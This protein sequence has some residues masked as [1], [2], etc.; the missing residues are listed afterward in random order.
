LFGRIV[1]PIVACFGNNE[2]AQLREEIKRKYPDIRFLDDQSII[3]KIGNTSVGIVGSIGSLDVPSTWQRRNVPNIEKTFKERVSF[4]DTHLK[5]LI[6]NFK[7]L[8]IHYSPTYKTLEGENPRFYG[9]LGSQLYE[10]VLIERK[11]T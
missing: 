5:N 6:V 10:N 2:F 9:N 1:C 8:L 4:V 7:I 3:L 11:L